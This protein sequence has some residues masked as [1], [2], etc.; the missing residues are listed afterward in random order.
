MVRLNL[1]AI[2]RSARTRY[3]SEFLLFATYEYKK[4]RRATHTGNETPAGTATGLTAATSVE[5]R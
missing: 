5:H 1:R 3:Q 2:L 4:L